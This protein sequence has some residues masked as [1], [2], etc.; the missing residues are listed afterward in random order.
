VSAVTRADLRATLEILG[1][2]SGAESTHPF[3]LE[4]LEQLGQL[5]GVHTVG[6]IETKT[7]H[8][9]TV[10]A[11]ELVTRPMPP[12]MPDELREW[13]RQDPTHATFH[14]HTARPLAI[15]DFLTWRT[16]SSLEVYQ[17]IC[18]RTDVKDS[19]RLYLPSKDG[20]ARFF[21]FDK[22]KRGFSPRERELLELLRPHLTHRRRHFGATGMPLA[23]LTPREAEIL[24]AAARGAS[25]REIARELWI[26]PHTVRT[27][28]EH[29]FEK[30][31]VRT[32][33]EA[34]ALLWNHPDTVTNGR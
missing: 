22:E 19:L 13:G 14:A 34:A 1:D 27:H 23:A 9:N 28:L 33:T 24:N 15:S 3:P 18:R 32:R 26:S 6:Y 16:F 20:E 11:Y 8:G 12:W 10:D 25:N 17:R 5:I 4:I 31:G 30:L 2:V 21:F 7:P 29:I